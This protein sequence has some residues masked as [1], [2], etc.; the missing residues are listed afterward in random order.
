MIC[1]YPLGAT[2][3][4]GCCGRWHWGIVLL[5]DSS[6]LIKGL[7]FLEVG[8]EDPKLILVDD[9]RY[10]FSLA[11]YAAAHR[12]LCPG[13]VTLRSSVSYPSGSCRRAW[14]A[15]ASFRIGFLS[16]VVASITKKR[17]RL[18]S[19]RR[20]RCVGSPAASLPYRQHPRQQLPDAQAHRPL[21]DPPLASCAV[22][23]F[24][25]EEKES[26]SKGENDELEAR[27]LRQVCS[28]RWPLTV[29]AGSSASVA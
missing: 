24:T 8:L 18:R 4:A 21:Q 23:P 10:C 20:A 14:W 2:P 11:R 17:R 16:A 19:R 13:R 15:Q 27:H 6:H 12:R 9:S 3:S 28:F 7:G 25:P 26:K 29:R 1:P 22:E 5:I